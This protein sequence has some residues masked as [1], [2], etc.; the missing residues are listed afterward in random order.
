MNCQSSILATFEFMIYIR[1]PIDGQS[2]RSLGKSISSDSLRISSE[3]FSEL[4]ASS[5]RC[6]KLV[7]SSEGLSEL[8]LF[9]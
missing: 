8:S 3:S 6:Y 7:L 1:A 5:D 4:D 2:F 9:L